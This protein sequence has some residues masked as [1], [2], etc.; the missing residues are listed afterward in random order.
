[1]IS[2]S[3]FRLVAVLA[4]LNICIIP[5]AGDTT[6]RPTVAV[7]YK[8]EPAVLMPGDTGTITVF[9]KNMATGEVYV[10]EN[11]ETFDMNAYLVSAALGGDDNIEALDKGYTNIGLLGPNDTIQLIFNVK[12][13]A[14]ATDGVHFLNFELVGGSEMYDLNY[15]IPVKIDKRELKII[16]SNIPSTVINEVSNI[17]VD[18]V[19]TRSNDISGVIVTPVC[20]DLIFT[21]SEIFVGDISPGNK[22][23][24]T[25]TFNT[26]GI[27]NGTKNISFSATYFNGD[28]L[29]K[30]QDNGTT[31]NIV[32]K[33]ALLLTDIKTERLGSKYTVTGEINNIGTTDMKNV[34]LSVLESGGIEPLQPYANCFVGTL[35]ADDISSFELSALINSS[36]TVKIPVLIEFR[37]NDNTYTSV[38]ESID[39]NNSVLPDLSNE[40]GMSRVEIAAAGFAC[41]AII[42]IIGYSWKKRDKDT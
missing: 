6:V 4:L 15:K 38:T 13:K 33:S 29:H 7:D 12:A 25:F 3:Y 31:V 22:S 9:L 11:D 39:L 20:D 34:K 17:T 14:D 24:M 21:P 2:N 32:D 19:N 41:F 28:N 27:G 35:E 1:M 10:K 23:T 8:I 42:G 16:K 18:V 40:E 26:I 30:A 37:S 36:N 5:V